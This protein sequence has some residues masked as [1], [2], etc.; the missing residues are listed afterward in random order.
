MKRRLFMNPVPTI[1]GGG[2]VLFVTDREH[3]YL[4]N[5]EEREE[6]GTQNILGAIRCGLVFQLKETI[7]AAEIRKR[8]NRMVSEALREWKKNPNIHILGCTQ[9]QRLP[10]SKGWL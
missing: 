1:P 10:V 3:R 7:G 4:D 6:A 8:E 5:P 2:T 9:S